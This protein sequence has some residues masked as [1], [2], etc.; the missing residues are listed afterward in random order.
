MLRLLVSPFPLMAAAF[1]LFSGC[2][3]TDTTNHFANF[4]NYVV[5]DQFAEYWYQGEAEINSYELKINRYGQDRTGDALLVFVTEDFSRSKQVKLDRPAKAGDDKVSVLKLNDIWKFKTG[6][7]D[8]SMMQSVFTPVERKQYPHSL[9]VTCSSQDW[10]G[11]SFQQLNLN[12]NNKDYT[13]RQF[14]YFES[15][16]DE[17][18]SL[19][20][21]ML[22][23]EIWTALRINPGTVPNGELNLLPGH[24]YSRLSHE[25]QE[26]KRARIRF[27]KSESLSTCIIEYLHLDRT[28]KINFETSFPHTILSW[29]E[30][31]GQQVMVDAQLK[32]RIKSPY[33]MRNGQQYLPLRDSLELTY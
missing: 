20:V 14:S 24:F 18:Y 13:Y 30:I 19:T 23:D 32:S 12:D 17:K 4:A 16:G 7:Y 29:K 10:C 3:A 31:Q 26:P 9:K 8:Y 21:D 11:H 25:K 28:L 27:E 22:E 33:W 5:P 15:E 6:I 2:Q 1:Y